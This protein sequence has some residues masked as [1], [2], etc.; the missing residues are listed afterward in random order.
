MAN[1]IVGL[2]KP[3]SGTIYID[4]TAMDHYDL[5]SYRSTIGYISQESVIFSDSIYNNITF[6]AEKTPDNIERFKEV[7]KIALLEDFINNQPEHEETKLGDN[8]ILISGGQRQRISIA[9]ELY[10]NTSIIVFDEAT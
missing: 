9:R 7:V 10:K 1:M 6:W 4:G 2:I 5:N 8:G 3:E